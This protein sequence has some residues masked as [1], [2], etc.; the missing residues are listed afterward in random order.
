MMRVISSPS[1]STTGFLTLIF[2]MCAE[3][4]LMEMGWIAEFGAVLAEGNAL[5]RRV[6]SLSDPRFR[7]SVSLPG[8]QVNPGNPA[9]FK[10]IVARAIEQRRLVVPHDEDIGGPQILGHRHFRDA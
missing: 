1:I 5:A 3:A 7:A 2:A 4:P 6:I 10:A 9:L 8:A